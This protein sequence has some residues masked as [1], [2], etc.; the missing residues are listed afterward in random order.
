MDSRIMNAPREVVG[1]AGTMESC[2]H[3]LASTIERNLVAGETSLAWFSA[4]I[5]DSVRMNRG[6]VRQPGTVVQAYFEVELVRGAR[7]ASHRLSL[8]GHPETDRERARSAVAG[9]RAALDDLDD[10]PHL[11]YSTEVHSTRTVHGSALSPAED[12][13]DAT[14]SAAEGLDLVGLYAGGPV[15]AGF[16]NSLGQRNWHQVTSF[17]LEWSLYDRT[18]K[19]VKSAL[20]GFEWDA[21]A[22]ASKMQAARNELVHVARPART[23]SP[24]K[25]RTYLSPAALED[26]VS[27]LCW[28]GFSARA[29][30]TRQSSLSRMRNVNGDEARLDPRVSM[31]DAIADGVAPAFQGDGFVRPASIPLIDA[32][33]LVGSLVSPRTAREFSL[34]ANGASGHESPVAL[35]MAG[36]TLAGAD[37]LAALG[38]G[39]YVGHLHY[40]NYSDRPACRMT[41]MTRFATFWVEDG[42]IVAPIDVL[43]FDDTIY[44]M[45]GSNLEALTAETELRLSSD[46]YRERSLVSMRL[47]GALISELTFTL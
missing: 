10:D 17:H 1:A 4:E 25:Y 20:S 5:S 16:A 36:G 30:A 23:L 7:H 12:I 2:F 15:C 28:G 43:R 26:V 27:L 21:A 19:A 45:L 6:K 18:D 34:E 24:G 33:K 13:V 31:H 3:D 32:G 8:S 29:L 11:L 35:A 9:L 38:T 42:K 40:L 47:P 14:L 44:R 22:L 39:L 41:G 46:T 37:A